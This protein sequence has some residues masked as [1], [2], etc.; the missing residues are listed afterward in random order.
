MRNVTISMNITLEQKN[1]IINATLVAKN[2]G[3]SVILCL[4]SLQRMF[5]R[6][7]DDSETRFATESRTRNWPVMR[8]RIAPNTPT[9]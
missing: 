1:T 8:T 9:A 7:L 2:M 5:I 6:K 4:S 3:D